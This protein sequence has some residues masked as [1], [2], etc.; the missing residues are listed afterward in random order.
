MVLSIFSVRNQAQKLAS[1][2]LASWVCAAATA[3]AID[4]RCFRH[5]LNFIRY[6]GI[7]SHPAHHQI[8]A[9]CFCNA[10]FKSA[11]V[12]AGYKTGFP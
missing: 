8:G 3:R 9:G 5:P 1:S 7:R 12:A 10:S 11:S 4:K 6:Q 2:K